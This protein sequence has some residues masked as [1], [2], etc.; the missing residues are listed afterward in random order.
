MKSLGHKHYQFDLEDGMESFEQRMEMEADQL[1]KDDRKIDLKEGKK[2][3]S[4]DSTQPD[5][6]QKEIDA[7]NIDSDQIQEIIWEIIDSVNKTARLFQN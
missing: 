2:S 3:D 1:E 4:V 5:M 7:R 6:K